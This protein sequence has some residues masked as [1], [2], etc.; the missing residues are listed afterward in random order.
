LVFN[1]IKIILA[2]SDDAV[3]IIAS[4]SRITLHA[5]VSDTYKVWRGIGAVALGLRVAALPVLV[6]IVTRPIVGVVLGLLL[7]IDKSNSIDVLI[8]LV[9]I[10]FVSPHYELFLRP[11]KPNRSH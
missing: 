8:V 2:S 10:V 9:I 6:N 7:T 3:G 4:V 5:I 1:L 11:L